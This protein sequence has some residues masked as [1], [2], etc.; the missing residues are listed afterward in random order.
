MTWNANGIATTLSVQSDNCTL[1]HRVAARSTCQY[2]QSSQYWDPPVALPLPTRRLRSQPD[3]VSVPPEPNL[4]IERTSMINIEEG[5]AF[6]MM[7]ECKRLYCASR[8][9]TFMPESCMD[10]SPSRRPGS[11]SRDT[12]ARPAQQA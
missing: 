2:R 6:E 8:S 3:A 11:P 4:G 9:F 12:C 10:T 7:D 1:C 5:I